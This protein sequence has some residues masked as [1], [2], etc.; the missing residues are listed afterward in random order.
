MVIASKRIL[1]LVALSLNAADDC[2]NPGTPPGAQ[3]SVGRFQTGDKVI[4]RCQAGLDLLGS[5]QRICL[6]SKEWSGSTPRCQGA[7]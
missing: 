5:A 2:N 6:E 1:S 7:E 3:R 4:Y